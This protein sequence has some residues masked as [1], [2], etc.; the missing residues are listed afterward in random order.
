MLIWERIQSLI[1][2]NRTTQESVADDIGESPRTFRGWI[3]RKIMPNAD[4]VYS[5]AKRFN[6]SVE[7][8]VAGEEGEIYLQRI[9]G[10]ASVRE[11]LRGLVRMLEQLPADDL[12]MVNLMVSCFYD[13][14]QAASKH[15]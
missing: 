14:Q 4:Q 10:T 8:L 12:N 15:G 2:A 1:V 9:M 6:T 3:Q 5:I 7:Y 11:E 13:R